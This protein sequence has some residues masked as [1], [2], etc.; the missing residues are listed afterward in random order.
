M[1]VGIV[2]LGQTL[3]PVV[4]EVRDDGCMLVVDG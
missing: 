4:E 1:E 2:H 3:P